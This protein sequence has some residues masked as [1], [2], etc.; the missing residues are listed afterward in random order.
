MANLNCTL[1]AHSKDT[2]CE[3]ILEDEGSDVE[4]LV[5]GDS[6]ILDLLIFVSVHCQH[7]LYK[8]KSTINAVRW[9]DD[10]ETLT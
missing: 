1:E 10:I 4:R 8:K 5:D 2:N 3:Q 9:W 7:I 6:I